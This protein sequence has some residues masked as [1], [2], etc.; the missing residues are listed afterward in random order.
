MTRYRIAFLSNGIPEPFVELPEGVRL[1]IMD[2]FV[3]IHL[4]SLEELTDQVVRDLFH[5]PQASVGPI[6]ILETDE[7]DEF[8]LFKLA[9]SEL[10]ATL[11]SS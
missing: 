11:V 8:D 9:E 2:G 7:W 5:D 1:V 4:A 10:K 3:P 6:G